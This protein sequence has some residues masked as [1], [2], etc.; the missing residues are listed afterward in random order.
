MTLTAPLTK[1]HAA[2]AAASYFNKR[3]L[4][5]YRA[6]L[7]KYGIQ[8]GGQHGCMNEAAGPTRVAAGKILGADYIGS[9]GTPPR[10]SAA[11]PT[12]S[13]RR[14]GQPDRQE[15]GRER[16]RAHL[17]PQP[18]AGVPHT[19]VD[20]GVL[21]TA[22]QIYM[23]R[24]RRALRRGRDRR[25]LGLGRLRRRHRHAV[26]A[27]INQ[28]PTKVK[29]LHIKDGRQH[30][31]GEPRR[32]SP[33]AC[34]QPGEPNCQNASARPTGFAVP[35]DRTAYDGLNFLPILNAA[36]GRVQY[37]HHE[38]DG[39]TPN[40]ADF[41]F[42]NLRGHQ[43]PRVVGTVLSK[44]VDLPVGRGRHAGGQQRRPGRADQHRRRA[45]EH[46]R[47]AT[48]TGYAARRRRGERL[49]D[50]EPEL[51]RRRDAARWPRPRSARRPGHAGRRDGLRH[52]ARHV[53]RSWSASRRGARATAPSRACRS[54]RA[55]TPRPSKSLLTGLST[56]DALSSVGGN[57]ASIMSLTHRQPRQLRL[58]PP[59]RRPHLRHGFGRDRHDHRRRRGAVGLRHRH[60]APGRLVN[61]TFAL[62]SAA[63]G[64]RGQR[65]AAQP[66]LRGRRRH[67]DDAAHVHRPDG[68]CDAVTL[69][70][71][72][73]IGATDVLRAGSY[74]KTLT[75][76]L[77]T[78]TP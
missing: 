52:P 15:L 12:R 64:P 7:D 3:G 43:R 33:L 41:S 1:A 17:H 6:L 60:V 27:L 18:P 5:E 50:R 2:G 37:Y 53:H 75:F 57:V 42:T 36:A 40:D 9:G 24:H 78:T 74:S 66:R 54:P 47:P 26:A 11:T 25:L 10:A 49:L 23:E 39:G 63:H 48:I 76:T 19:L 56:N 30:R 65:G 67:A 34:G 62:P 51:H 72:Q 16:R 22:L 20:K 46:H 71:R 8:A 55:P 77:S 44:P 28:F 45:A 35:A 73:A 29:L 69:G 58:V 38:Q 14:D 61:G 21:K 68:R 31:A 32:S 70:F 59:G 13:D 4:D